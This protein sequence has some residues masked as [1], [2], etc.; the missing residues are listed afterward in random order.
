[1]I[2]AIISYLIISHIPHVR[3]IDF[4]LIFTE[5]EKKSGCG[6]FA[7]NYSNVMNIT[8][9]YLEV[10]MELQKEKCIP[11]MGNATPLTPEEIEELARNIPA[12]RV[13][14]HHSIPRLVRQF[15]YPDFSQAMR[16]AIEVGNLAEEQG[17]HP[18]MLIEYGRVTISW[19]THS[20][21]G[22]HRNDFI[23]AA[24]TDN[25]Q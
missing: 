15:R 23:M 12:W 11:C 25:I 7:A 4:A 19:W 17:H 10:T 20:I 18:A 14:A 6:T 22:L 1:M 9:L 13:E 24:K 8:A 16:F 5:P 21:N 3:S 2:L